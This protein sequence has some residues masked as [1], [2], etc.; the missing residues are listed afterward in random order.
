MGRDR[1]EEEVSNKDILKEIKEMKKSLDF[2]NA[3]FEE[4]KEENKHLKQLLKINSK[5]NE[6]LEERLR[7]VEQQLEKCNKEEILNNIV[8]TGVEKQNKNEVL[9]DTAIKILKTLDSNINSNDIVTAYKKDEVKEKSVIIVKLRT[10]ELKNTIIKARKNIGSITTKECNLKGNNNEIYINEQLTPL[11]NV[12]FYK[13][14][15]LKK[16]HQ[17]KYLWTRDG[18]IYIKK[19]DISNKIK[20][21]THSDLEKIK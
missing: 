13:A 10:N 3:Q 4:V 16:E 5:K 15:Q 7:Y 21:N 8:I 17:Y 14:R 9:Q 6:N 11:K 19:T 18:N 1:K 12:L 20:I 2:L